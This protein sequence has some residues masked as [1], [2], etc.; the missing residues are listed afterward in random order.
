[1]EGLPPT[2][3]HA[4]TRTPRPVGSQ[5]RN[6]DKTND[7]GVANRMGPTV[8]VCISSER[9]G[10]VRYTSSSDKTWSGR[11]GAVGLSTE[12]YATTQISLQVNACCV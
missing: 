10:A 4:C 5:Q 9:S 1:M 11:R 3:E 2:P 6:R 12:A 7:R 8:S